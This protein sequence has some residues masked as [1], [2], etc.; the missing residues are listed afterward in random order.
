MNKVKYIIIVNNVTS[1][2]SFLGQKT[3][4]EYV[5]EKTM[6]FYVYIFNISNFDHDFEVTFI[7]LRWGNFDQYLI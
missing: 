4:G 1:L 6:C 5:N 3:C 2:A 7:A